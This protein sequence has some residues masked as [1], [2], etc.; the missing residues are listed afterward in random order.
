MPDPLGI[1]LRAR[2]TRRLM[3]DLQFLAFQADI[4]RVSTLLL[5]AEN[6]RTNY[7]E[8]GLTGHYSTSHHGNNPE[9]LKKYSKLTATTYRCSPS[10]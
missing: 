5:A 6:S 10:S 2:S 8:I 3:F 7:A 9:T 4:T 1:P